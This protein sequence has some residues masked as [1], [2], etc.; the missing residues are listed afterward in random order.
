LTA[1]KP[2]LPKALKVIVA[3]VL[4][5]GLLVVSLAAILLTDILLGNSRSVPTEL[6]LFGMVAA[7]GAFVIFVG[8]SLR[9]SKRWAR[10]AALFWQLI[11]L[12][13]A[14]G[15]F[16]GQFG[17]WFIGLGLIIPSMIVAVLIFRKDV[18]EA[19]MAEVDKD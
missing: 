13:I 19:T 17:N 8:W 3:V 11:Q 10:S 1:S 18:V 2:S 15:S 7:A 9:K 14:T 6:A 4:A 5:E 16:T 12:A